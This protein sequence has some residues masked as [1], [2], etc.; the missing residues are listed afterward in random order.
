[1]RFAGHHDQCYGSLQYNMVRMFLRSVLLA[2]IPERHGDGTT[3]DATSS[4]DIELTWIGG[5]NAWQHLGTSN[6]LTNWT[7]IL[8]NTPPTLVTNTVINTGSTTAMN[9][10]YR[11]KAVR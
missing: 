5:V 11:I 2:G 4:N 8:T 1:M 10:F 7:A 9:L 6:T 3:T